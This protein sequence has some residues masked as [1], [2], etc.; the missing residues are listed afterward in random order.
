MEKGLKKAKGSGLGRASAAVAS[1]LVATTTAAATAGI[2]YSRLAIRH[3]VPLPAALEAERAEIDLEGAGRISYYADTQAAGTPLVL[4]HSVNAAASALELKPLFDHYRRQ[5][6]VYALDLPGYGFSDRQPRPYTAAFFAQVINNF[7]E[8]VVSEPADVITL[9]LSSEFGARA[10]LA[11]PEQ[12]RSLTLIS[13]SGFSQRKTGR[14]TEQAGMRGAGELLY[15]SL[16]F[17]LWSQALYDLIVSRPSLRFYLGKSFV[18]DI[19]DELVDYGYATSHQPGAKNVPLTFLSGQ[20]FTQDALQQLY[21]PLKVPALILYDRDFYVR[22]DLLPDLL[23]KNE[24]VQAVRVAPT[25]GLPHWEQLEE[26]AGALNA[27]W[28]GVSPS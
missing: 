11:A 17:P 2:L 20:L 5:R 19:P 10:A 1:G 7:L 26:T 16:S 3:D 22:F 27:F 4:I 28:A 6:P 9:S 21:V 12:F 25:M 8:Q 13:P 15:K 14:A 24:H 18:G 23:A